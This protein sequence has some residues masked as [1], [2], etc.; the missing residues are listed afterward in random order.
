MDEYNT[1]LLTFVDVVLL[2][3]LVANVQSIKAI[4]ALRQAPPP[5]LSSPHFVLLPKHPSASSEPS[6]ASRLSQSSPPVV[7]LSFPLLPLPR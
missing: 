2:G 7:P 4:L 5:F 6:H 1:V 3:C